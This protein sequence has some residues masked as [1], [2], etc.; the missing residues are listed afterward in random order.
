LVIAVQELVENL[1][2][3]SSGGDDSLVF[4][5]GLVLDQPRVT[6]ETRNFAAAADLR[7][8]TEIVSRIVGALDASSLYD[9]MVAASGERAGSRLGLIRVRAEGGLVLSSTVD[10]GRLVLTATGPVSARW[11]ES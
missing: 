8:A 1:V 5:L 4:E 11:G 7:E 6:I 9:E 3:Y 2:K 10:S